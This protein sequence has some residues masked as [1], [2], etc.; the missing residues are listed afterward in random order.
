VASASSYRPVRR[1]SNPRKCGDPNDLF[2]QF[3]LA[4]T[5][6][7][8]R[9]RQQTR[10][11]SAA[12]PWCFA[13]DCF[14]TGFGC[15]LKGPSARPR[16]KRVACDHASD[17]SSN[18]AGLTSLNGEGRYIHRSGPLPTGQCSPTDFSNTGDLIERAAQNTRAWID[19]GG[20]SRRKVPHLSL[21]TRTRIDAFCS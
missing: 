11:R 16:L 6:W 3:A 7:L 20:L 18:R 8:T 2:L 15:A 4:M 5:S 12:E 19:E 14:P 13:S 10:N 17:R 1:R 21:L 9:R